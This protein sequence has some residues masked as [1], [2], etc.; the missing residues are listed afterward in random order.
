M[1]L[2]RRLATISS[3]PNGED[4]GGGEGRARVWLMSL[5]TRL[6]LDCLLGLASIQYT[7]LRPF[8]SE[9]ERGLSD[10]RRQREFVRCTA[11]CVSNLQV[12]SQSMHVNH[13]LFVSVAVRS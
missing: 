10:E 2:W 1:G 3:P 9:G 12:Q 4:S 7:T 5:L 6:K 11:Y 8:G 13:L